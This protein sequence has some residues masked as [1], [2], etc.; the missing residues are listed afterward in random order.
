MPD[1]WLDDDEPGCLACGETQFRASRVTGVCTECVEG[2]SSSG[3]HVVEDNERPDD[4]QWGDGWT[5]S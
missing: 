1:F 2:E 3:F 5:E 4:D